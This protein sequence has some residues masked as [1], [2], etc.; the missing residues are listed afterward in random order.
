MNS[1]PQHG[2]ATH[3]NISRAKELPLYCADRFRCADATTL[4]GLCTR[5]CTASTVIR[6]EIWDRCR[7]ARP[8]PE[9]RSTSELS[10]NCEESSNLESCM[11]AVTRYGL[12]VIRWLAKPKTLGGAPSQV[13]GFGFVDGMA[14]AGAH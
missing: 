11:Q 2:K 1:Y 3:S 6:D 7:W 13:I 12:S 10:R 4:R 8:V 9:R 14:R 5:T